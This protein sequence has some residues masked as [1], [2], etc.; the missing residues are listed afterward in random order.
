M[1][2][3]VNWGSPSESCDDFGPLLG[4]ILTEDY[5][6]DKEVTVLGTC[7]N[8]LH[9]IKDYNVIKDILSK[10]V[11]DCVICT[12]AAISNNDKKGKLIYRSSGVRPGIGCGRST[13]P[14]G[15]V[16]ILFAIGDNMNNLPSRTT[17]INKVL[18]AAT[19]IAQIVNANKN[20]KYI[21]KI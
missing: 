19:I 2:Y 10:S 11:V 13:E 3:I 21:Y 4:T 18:D 8:P 20:K 17:K 16:G 1:I 9:T 7:K 15:D 12:D 5:K 6:F 14:I